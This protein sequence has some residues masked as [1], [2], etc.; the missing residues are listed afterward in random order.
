MCPESDCAR[1]SM[2]AREARLNPL[3]SGSAPQV[4]PRRL[5]SVRNLSIGPP[6]RFCFPLP[7]LTVVAKVG[8]VR[9]L[10]GWSRV[11][12]RRPEADTARVQ[13]GQRARPLALEPH[14]PCGRGWPRQSSL[15]SAARRGRLLAIPR[16]SGDDG[17]M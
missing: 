1:H 17:V 6:S 15:R 13:I 7:A 3:P 5:L 11:P 12:E 16:S 10:S 2:H 4:A 8:V 9:C 14:R